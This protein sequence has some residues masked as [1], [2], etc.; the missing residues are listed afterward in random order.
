MK[1]SEIAEAIGGNLTGDGSIE[2]DSC[3]STKKAGK[4]D[5]TF[6]DSEKFLSSIGNAPSV[7]AVIV[8][9]TV[10][11]A[12]PKGVPYIEV[13]NP[14][15][16]F[17][18]VMK[19]L[20]PEPRPNLGVHPS[21]VVEST[22]KIGDGT[23]IGA[24]TYIGNNAVIGKNCVIHANVTIA[25]G[26]IVG[27]DALIYPQVAIIN[28]TVM[29]D[30]CIIHAGSAIGTDG[31]KFAPDGE[32]GM[33]KVPHIGIVRIGN[34]VEIGGNCVI[35]RAFLDETVLGDRV[36]FDNL[37]HI[38]HN[39]EIGDGTLIAGQNGIAGSTK[40]GKGVMTGGQVGFADH[41]T[42]ADGSMFAAQS[43]VIGNKDEQGT[44]AGL[45]AIP[46]MQ[47]RRSAAAILKVPELIRKVRKLEQKKEQEND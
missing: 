29:G 30:R 10:G 22:A 5:I 32:G 40:I 3:A 27:D 19:L 31:F 26:C 46:I 2:I 14:T 16:A 23:S 7:S 36:K 8:G 44:Y 21:A 47:W 17:V 24:L 28:G 6:V 38:A 45:P 12:L 9:E 35:D 20:H 41:I 43:G 37:V 4:G 39:V 13:K 1:L 25:A 18:A 34:D 33:A 11:S 42:V 15:M